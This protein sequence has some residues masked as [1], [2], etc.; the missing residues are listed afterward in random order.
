[1]GRVGVAGVRWTGAAVGSG[2]TAGGAGA[3]GYSAVNRRV[4]CQVRFDSH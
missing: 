3:Q 2:G 4:R 1:M